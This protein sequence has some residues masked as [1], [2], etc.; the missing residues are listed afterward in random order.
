[1]SFDILPKSVK[2]IIK[3]YLF[4]KCQN[5]NQIKQFDS[6]QHKIKIFKYKNIFGIDY[7]FPRFVN[8]YELICNKCVKNCLC[9]GNYMICNYK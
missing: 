1:M 9:Y 7:D 5:C 8:H 4:G 3:E 2:N 6:L